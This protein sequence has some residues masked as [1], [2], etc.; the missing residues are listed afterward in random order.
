MPN[1]PGNEPRGAAR[2]AIH[3]HAFGFARFALGAMFGL[4]L[5]STSIAQQVTGQTTPKP[6]WP[7]NGIAQRMF[8]GGFNMFVEND[9]GKWHAWV[10]ESGDDAHVQALDFFSGEQLPV[11]AGLLENG[12]QDRNFTG[13]KGTVHAG[14][15]KGFM[16]TL[17]GASGLNGGIG[18]AG[19]TLSLDGADYHCS[20]TL[21]GVNG[22]VDDKVGDDGTPKWVKVPIYHIAPRQGGCPSGNFK[23]SIKTALDLDDGTFLVTMGCWVFHLRKSDLS[24]VGSAPGL[25]II[26]EASVQA[27]I[28]QAKGKN[29]Q[30]ATGY[31]AKALNLT[32]DAAT[33]CDAK[34]AH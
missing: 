13:A 24:P 34:V 22:G 25:R 5:G 14:A 3:H 2:Y 30:D 18:F 31:L 16:F 33:S 21:E 19:K 28:D 15:D 10:M 23:S 12:Q 6:V 17:A 27:A 11:K 29:I 32:F 4:A 26:D 7:D 20:T 8:P 9:H 1:L